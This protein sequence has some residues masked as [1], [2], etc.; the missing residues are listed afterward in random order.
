M[1]FWR[2]SEETGKVVI[3][4]TGHTEGHK[5]KQNEV[6]QA[7]LAWKQALEDIESLALEGD[8]SGPED[9]FYKTRP[10]LPGA[11]LACS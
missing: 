9:I 11:W 4:R 10:S 2:I 3:R 6:T 1:N 5:H 8:A 7:M